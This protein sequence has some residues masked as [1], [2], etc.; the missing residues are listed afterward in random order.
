MNPFKFFNQNHIAYFVLGGVLAVV[1]A[2]VSYQ[3]RLSVAPDEKHKQIQADFLSNEQAFDKLFAKL[4][5]DPRIKTT[6]ELAAFCEN[7]H[8]NSRDFIFYIYQDAVLSAWSSNEITAADYIDKTD[9]VVF[10]YIDNKWVYAKRADYFT[11]KY[12]GYIVLNEEEGIEY[13]PLSASVAN[14][15]QSYIIKDNSGEDAFRLVVNKELKKSNLRSFL[16][17]CLWLIAFSFLC[18]ALVAFLLQ[19][20]FFKSNPHRLF[21]LIVPLL[22]VPTKIFFSYLRPSEDLFS[23]VYYSSSV[24]GSLGELLIYSYIAFF[25]STL[26]MQHFTI[27]RLLLLNKQW[28]IVVS[29]VFTILVLL[30]DFFAY[31]VIKSVASDS[32]V[33]LTPEIIY[34]N[35]LSI[36]ALL[37]IVFILWTIFIITYRCFWEI[38]HHLRNKR[39]FILILLGGFVG[40]MFFVLLYDISQRIIFIQHLLF[41]L[42]MAVVAFSIIK[43]I[44]WSNIIFHTVVY[45]I[46]SSLV[47]Y[48]TKQMVEEREEK[49]KESI[50]ERMLSVQ[51]PFVL[52]GFSELA[53]NIL[54]DTNIKNLFY[55]NPHSAAEMERYIISAHLSKYTEDYRISIET[56]LQSDSLRLNQFQHDNYTDRIS[57]SDT[58]SFRSIGFG[59]SEYTLNLPFSLQ[60]I[61]DV[62][63]IFIVFRFYVL[64]EELSYMEESIQ[65]EM[66]NYSYAGYQNNSLKM[67]VNKADVSY[68]YKLSDYGLDTIY[69]GMKFTQGSIEHTVFKHDDMILLVSAKK[70]MIWGRLSFVVVL[71]FI[72]FVF[73]LVPTTFSLLWG[74]QKM[75]RPGFHD[76]MQFYVTILVAI[77]IITTAVLFSRFFTNLRNF[78]RMEFRNQ[79]ANKVKEIM[80]KSIENRYLTDLTPEIV[81]HSS[82]ELES[83]FNTDLLNLNLYN[84]NGELIKSYGKGIYINTHINPY[85]LKQFS[86]DRY[87]AATIDEVFGKEQYK[88]SYRTIVDNSGEVVGYLNLLTF[89]EKRNMLDPRHTQFLAQFMLMCLFATLLIVFLSLVLIRRLTRPLSKVTERLSTI[90]I[91]G[92][93][94]EIEWTRDDEFGK[95][96]ET[97]NFLI[98]KLRISTELLERDSQEL[99]WKDM[100]KQVAHE[101]KNPLTPMRLTTQQIMRQLS[102]ENIDKDR[103]NDYFNMIL[104]Q[105]DTLTDIAASF[106]NFA[107]ANQ[108]DGSCQDLYAIIKDAISAYNEEDVEIVLVNDT[109]QDAVLSF[110]SHSQTMQVFNNLIK[111]AIQAKKPDEK[112]TITIALQH[113]GD[114]M[115]QVRISDTGTGMTDEVKE[116]LFLP[117]FTTKTSGMGLGLAVVKQII[118]AH[119]GSTFFESTLGEG[120]TFWITLPK[121]GMRGEG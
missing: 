57:P 24:Y 102:N 96:V 93:E 111:N 55:Q 37:S 31:Q 115:W 116:K 20:T 43:P 92:D 81:Q 40:A 70:G 101:I 109:E 107:Q 8:I 41:L 51:D 11:N 76:A 120:T 52:D 71:F 56:T 59:K 108:R 36:A 34:R 54:S 64:S 12:I 53:Q 98:A 15:G 22:V 29:V 95:L 94:P 112:Q 86:T 97:Y 13:L 62:G 21:L 42:F 25:L 79:M 99:A 27:K 117:N 47:L 6:V 17:V 103:L 100:A 72:Q 5:F 113:H 74:N 19:K 18:F 89:G 1:A 4:T 82:T 68:F 110:V 10:Q 78:D 73:W 83:F 32:F 119:G 77:T 114:K 26:F 61:N 88:S 60:E 45:L 91:R 35:V 49:Y 118:T 106:S 9:S 121:L 7:N 3:G 85:V 33:I 63:R 48:S 44:K 2:V 38:F 14:A 39:I 30:F 58:V 50:S 104:A 105:T 69:S 90:S 75:W 28:K 23:S 87:G 80:T 66:D 67:N 65:K 46:L 16:E 84:K